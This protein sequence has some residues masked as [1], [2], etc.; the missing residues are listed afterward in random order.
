MHH[1]HRN[2]GSFTSHLI[3]FLLIG[4]GIALT[5]AWYTFQA[6]PLPSWWG[7]LAAYACFGLFVFGASSIYHAV[8]E[9]AEPGHEEEVERFNSLD[10]TAIHLLIAGTGTFHMRVIPVLDQ[11]WEPWIIAA[12]W[13]LAIVG[14]LLRWATQLG[15]W[16][17]LIY[18][19]MLFTV[20]PGVGSLEV[21]SH[22]AIKVALAGIILYILSAAFF[23]LPSVLEAKKPLEKRNE[24]KRVFLH[25][26]WH[27]GTSIAYFTA[28][29]AVFF[30]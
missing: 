26:L 6:A 16:Q 17:Y 9:R 7:S 27:F 4:F 8:E 24:K 5:F 1:G 20:L 30:S 15:S 13:A 12:L 19:L 29:A 11:P 22:P 2:H 3:P 18:G 25:T 21:L 14:I 23:F 28:G 10:H